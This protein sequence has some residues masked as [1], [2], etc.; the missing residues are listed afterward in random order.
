MIGTT[1]SGKIYKGIKGLGN[2]ALISSPRASEEERARVSSRSVASLIRQRILQL[3]PPLTPSPTSPTSPPSSTTP[4]PPNPQF[5]MASAIK[6][7]VFKGVGNEDP[8]QFWF[9]VRAVWEAQGVMDDNIKKATLVSVL[10]DRTL[11]W[12][13]KHSNDHTNAGIVEIEY[14]LNK[15]F[16]WPKSETQSIIG[17]KE[18][19]MLPGETP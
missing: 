2:S 14:A 11:T 9:V 1:R 15:E 16:S 13:I 4:P 18:I 5:S 3:S 17:F 10:H 12:Y 8:D 6:R 7:P 19:T